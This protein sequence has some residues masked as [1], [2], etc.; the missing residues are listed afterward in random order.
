M[1]DHTV[2]L[3]FV[4]KKLLYHFYWICKNNNSPNCC[5]MP[6]YVFLGKLC[7]LQAS[8]VPDQPYSSSLMCWAAGIFKGWLLVVHVTGLGSRGQT[9]PWY[10]GTGL[11]QQTEPLPWVKEGLAMTLLLATASLAHLVSDFIFLS[12]TRCQT[13]SF[14][15]GRRPTWPD[16]HG[17]SSGTE[18]FHLS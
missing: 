18:S 14:T 8:Y 5:Q 6:L 16:A 11:G 7:P 4:A 17:W 3:C 12:F 13:L 9:W 10:I 2:P 15:C 1:S